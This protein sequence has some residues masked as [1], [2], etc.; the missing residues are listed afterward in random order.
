VRSNRLVD[1]P[2]S[3]T[4]LATLLAVAL[5]GAAA[6]DTFCSSTAADNGSGTI[7]YPAPAATALVDCAYDNPNDRMV[8]SNGLPAGTTISIEP[9]LFGYSQRSVS[10]GGNLAGQI[11]EFNSTLSMVMTGTGAL[12][13]FSRSIQMQM[14]TEVHLAP[15]DPGAAVQSQ[16]TELVSL[17]G[18]LFGDPDFDSLRVSAGTTFSLPASPGTT[19]LTRPGA[20]GADF[21]VD[22][23]FDITYK[24]E[25]VGAPG[26]ALEGFG[27][28]TQ[29]EIILYTCPCCEEPDTSSGTITFPG[30]GCVYRNPDEPLIIDGGLPAGTTIEA[31]AEL[32]GFTSLVTGSGGVLGGEFSQFDADL[33]LAISGTGALAGFNRFITVPMSGQ[34]DL[35]SRTRN[36]AVQ[37]FETEMVE[38]DGQLFG[39]PDFDS[40]QVRF[41][42]N[43]G[44]AGAGMATLT[45]L[46]PVGANFMVDSFFDIVYRI[47][48]AGAPGSALEGFSG[49]SYG[50]VDLF[51]CNS[52]PTVF[53]D[54]FET[55]NVSVWSASQP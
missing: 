50:F 10:L 6:A 51:C 15:P 49:S 4:A 17:D 28:T 53:L 46:G 27:G 12:T 37:S 5:T 21:E 8:I 43:F 55:G 33:E 40:I 23:F 18:Q 1:S 30:L 48:F 44:F 41:G 38:L 52:S 3:V 24:I 39:D 7:D 47:D 2:S 19:T 25:F 13:G 14:T 31:F 32:D 45:R 34:A 22:S 36:D 20:P 26:S 16:K 42:R 29:A 54:G 9:A 11:V 35:A